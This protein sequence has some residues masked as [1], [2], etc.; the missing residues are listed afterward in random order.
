MLRQHIDEEHMDH[1]TAVT[2]EEFARAV[3]TLEARQDAENENAMHTEALLATLTEIGSDVSEDAVLAEVERQRAIQRES[4]DVARRMGQ[5]RSRRSRLV[6]TVATCLAIP[7][8]V[9]GS[10]ALHRTEMQAANERLASISAQARMQSHVPAPFKL[11]AQTLVLDGESTVLT[12]GEIPDGHPVRVETN[13]LELGG[14]QRTENDLLAFRNDPSRWWTIVKHDGAPYLRVFTTQKLS[15]GTLRQGL[16]VLLN[17][18][19]KDPIQ[20]NDD[21]SGMWQTR[22]IAVGN[23]RQVTIPLSSIRFDRMLG[24]VR[25]GDVGWLYAVEGIQADSHVFER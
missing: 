5:R 8:L 24:G 2:S 12:L 7:A 1:A 3:A 4:H 21:S 23:P 13:D 11:T 19:T 9:L 22:D 17:R 10:R 15:A 14:M 6:A 25:V 20:F 16:V 18:P